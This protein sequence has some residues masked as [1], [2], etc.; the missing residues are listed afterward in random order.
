MLNAKK[1][2]KSDTCCGR[3]EPRWTTRRTASATT[4]PLAQLARVPRLT[5]KTIPREK[6]RLATTRHVSTSLSARA[7]CPTWFAA[8][9]ARSTTRSERHACLTRWRSTT[10]FS[11]SQTGTCN[12][13]TKTISL[14]LFLFLF[15]VVIFMR[16]I[17]IIDYFIRYIFLVT[18]LHNTMSPTLNTPRAR[19]L[20]NS[21]QLKIIII[22]HQFNL[23]YLFVILYILLELFY[24]LQRQKKSD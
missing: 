18:L 19:K 21:K 1:R 13:N 24:K 4:W 14:N 15:F 10:S 23:M 20:Y 12:N 2:A 16:W 7:T 11:K 5:A 8:S 3:T 9:T 17:L 6:H 22:I